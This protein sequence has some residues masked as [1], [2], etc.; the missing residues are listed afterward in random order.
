MFLWLCQCTQA[1]TLLC[2][3]SL[4]MQGQLQVRHRQPMVWQM[5]LEGPG[6]HYLLLNTGNPLDREEVGLSCSL[7]FSHLLGTCWLSSI[8][9]T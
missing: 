5:I 7:T 1:I 4:P 8:D 3:A 2:M 9:S 6:G